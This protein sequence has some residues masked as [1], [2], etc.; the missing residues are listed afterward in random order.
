MMTFLRLRRVQAMHALPGPAAGRLPSRRVP[1]KVDLKTGAIV[2]LEALTIG[3][4]FERRPAQQDHAAPGL[5]LLR[6]IR[7]HSRECGQWK[8]LARD[9][10]PVEPAA[11]DGL[12]AASISFSS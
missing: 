7:Q 3:R 1:A 4:I 9:I 2:G 8:V 5:Q 11:L 10:H 12:T 6:D